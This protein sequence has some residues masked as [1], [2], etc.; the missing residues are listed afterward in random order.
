MKKIIPLLILL[1]TLLNFTSAQTWNQAIKL[2]ASDRT[3]EDFFG[4]AIAIYGDYAII[5]APY[6]DKDALSQNSLTNSG[7]AYIF[8][9]N[10]G[11]WSQIQKITADDRAEWDMFGYSVS[12]FGDYAIVGAE[13]TNTGAGSVYVFKNES[14]TW[15]QIQKLNASDG[16]SQD[17][18]GHSVSIYADHIIVGAVGDSEDLNG[19]SYMK[20]AG[21]AYIFRNSSDTWTQLQ[22]ISPSDRNEEDRFGGSVAIN[23]DYAIIGSLADDEDSNGNNYAPNAGS[24]YIYKLDNGTWNQSQKITADDREGSDLFGSA[25]ALSEDFIIVGAHREDHDSEGNNYLGDAGSVY[26]YKNESDTWTQ[27]QK[28]TAID[29]DSPDFFGYSISIFGDYILVG[30]YEEDEDILGE[31]NLASAGSAYL[32]KNESGTWNQVQKIT[33]SDRGESD[34]F[35]YA[36]A[37]YGDYAIIGAYYEDEDA[38][39]NNTI[40]NAG[41][42]YIYYNSAT[43]SVEE[44]INPTGFSIEQ[45]FPNPFNPSTS[46]EYTVPSNEYVNLKVYD[47]LGNEV[48]QLVNEKKDAGRYRV[49]FD[50]SSLSSGIYF[51]KI[52]AGSFNQ[53]RKMMLVK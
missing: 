17:Y 26:I 4:Y 38:N 5:G 20:H 43:V 3:S 24:A 47:V 18:F 39:Q 25:V 42:A 34:L 33:A 6:D 46:I 48:A 12:M 31:N 7:S 53:V 21:S 2:T 41:S 51:Y 32:F 16:S 36:V 22:K 40:A 10:S 19:S 28:I 9:N 11:N 15:T 29:R 52:Q 23:R 45:N 27:A 35:A 14:G 50:A 37:I 44:A 1:S 49:N 8:K 13:G 30:A